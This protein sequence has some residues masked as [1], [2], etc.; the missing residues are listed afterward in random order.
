MG[1]I[2]VE[3]MSQQPR[4]E[5]CIDN[6]TCDKHFNAEGRMICKHGLCEISFQDSNFGTAVTIVCPLE[7]QR[8]NEKRQWRDF[9]DNLP[10]IQKELTMRF[11]SEKIEGKQ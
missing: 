8:L 5:L 1:C 3:K 2:G 11:I 9:F 4:I 6:T 10:E 7:I